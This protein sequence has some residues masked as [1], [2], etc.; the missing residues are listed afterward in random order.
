MEGGFAQ[1]QLF[2]QVKPSGTSAVTLFTTT[3]RTEVTLLLATVLT[4]TP[5]VEVFHDDDG[6]TFDT[7]TQIYLATRSTANHPIIYQNS[8]NGSG[9]M[10]RAG[11]SLGI[12]VSAA[13]SVTFSLYGIT[14]TR[15]DWAYSKG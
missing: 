13:N 4:G 5:T 2:A 3:M 8:G 15:A 14:E 6:T 9:I 1:G 7:T 10:I 11:G 12:K